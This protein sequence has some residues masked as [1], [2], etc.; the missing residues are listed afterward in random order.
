MAENVFQYCH[1]KLAQFINLVVKI[2]K[3]LY[4]QQITMRKIVESSIICLQSVCRSFRFVEERETR[5]K[6]CI[7]CGGVDTKAQ[8]SSQSFLWGQG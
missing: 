5:G 1:T 8:L 7:F 4:S 2:G 3:M 6:P